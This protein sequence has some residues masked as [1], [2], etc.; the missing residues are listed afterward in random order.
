L[1]D[2]QSANVIADLEGSRFP[3]QVILV[4]AHLDSW[5]LGTGALDDGAGLGIIFQVAE[6]MTSI[7]LRPLRTIRFMAWT[8]EEQGGSGFY[9]YLEDHK[10]ELKN[11][12]AAFTAI[13]VG[14]CH[15]VGYMTDTSPRDLEMMGPLA[16]VLK[17]QGAP[18]IQTSNQPSD[19]TEYGVVSFDPVVDFRNYHDYH[20]T[21]ADTFDKIDLKGLQENSSLVA[22][23]AYALASIEPRVSLK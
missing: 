6:A 9:Q 12:V 1:P 18:V 20:H 15:P 7:H 21:A 23:L 14:T 22:V 19:V 17:A 13:D 8:N 2:A 4:S 16:S 3:E 11:H 10:A 5:D